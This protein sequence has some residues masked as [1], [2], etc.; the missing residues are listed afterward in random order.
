[1]K[2]THKLTQAQINSMVQEYLNKL[3]TKTKI[4]DILIKYGI[5]NKMTLYYHL[6]KYYG[7]HTQ[8]NQK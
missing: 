4:K 7:K 5:Q 2:Q 6:N 3:R 8:S 1:M